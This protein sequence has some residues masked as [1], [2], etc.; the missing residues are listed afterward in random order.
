[1]NAKS[2]PLF[3]TVSNKDYF[4][5]MI[6][7]KVDGHKVVKALNFQKQ[8]VSTAADVPVSSV[9]YD[10]KMPI[11]LRDRLFEWAAAI[12]LVASYFKDASKTMLWFQVSNP[13][14][15]GISP[16][17]MIRLRKF[18]KLMKFIHSALEDNMR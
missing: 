12:N 1:M 6:N 7:G 3:N 2:H 11:D 9:R 14:L 17:D 16:R 10:D 18:K 4:G 8:D 15:G 5:L 13:Q